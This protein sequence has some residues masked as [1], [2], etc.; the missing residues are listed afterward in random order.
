MDG[1]KPLASVAVVCSTVSILACVFTIPMLY[2]VIGEMH[3]EILHGANDFRVETDAAWN[4]VMKIQVGVTAPSEPRENPFASIARRKRQNF[5]GLPAHCVCEPPKL[6]CPPGPP[7]PQGDPGPP[8]RKFHC[9]V[10]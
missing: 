8:G 3:D 2:I 1:A 9:H 6:H 7:G 4:E 5:S 10:R